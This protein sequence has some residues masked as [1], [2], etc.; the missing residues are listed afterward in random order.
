MEYQ[1]FLLICSPRVFCSDYT[2][3]RRQRGSPRPKRRNGSE[4]C[5][6]WIGLPSM[7]DLQKKESFLQFMGWDTLTQWRD[8]LIS[9]NWLINNE[10]YVLKRLTCI[11]NSIPLSIYLSTY[12]FDCRTP[13][14][15]ILVSIDSLV[16]C[17]SY[18][19][20]FSS[21]IHLY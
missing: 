21:L 4:E 12:L 18:M 14:Y 8:N 19:M 1:R 5:E 16:S 17:S 6:S 20:S 9:V 13:T 11:T 10:V 7:E 2:S 15:F 3:P